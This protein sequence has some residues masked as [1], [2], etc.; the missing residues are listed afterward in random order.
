MCPERPLALLS[1]SPDLIKHVFKDSII[2]RFLPEKLEFQNELAPRESCKKLGSPDVGHPSVQC[3]PAGSGMHAVGDLDITDVQ[4]VFY[5]NLPCKDRGGAIYVEFVFGVVK[6]LDPRFI[7]RESY[8]V[9]DT[10]IQVGKWSLW[11]KWPGEESFLSFWNGLIEDEPWLV[12]C[13][14]LFDQVIHCSHAVGWV[15]HTRTSV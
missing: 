11:S 6:Y 12:F 14:H 1:L 3:Q 2:F 10:I 7:S 15:Y 9:R 8:R 13:D 4:R 5:F